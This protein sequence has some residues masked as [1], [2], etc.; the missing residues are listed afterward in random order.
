MGEIAIELHCTKQNLAHQAVQFQDAFGI[1]FAR[2]RS[3]E[4]RAAMRQARLGGPNRNT[5][6]AHD[7][8][9]TNSNQSA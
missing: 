3:K 2:C 4:A 9:S 5:K 6:K 7:E 1:K 8:S